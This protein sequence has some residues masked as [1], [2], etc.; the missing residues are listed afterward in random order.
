M[1]I[2]SEPSE[3]KEQYGSLQCHDPEISIEQNYELLLVA[4]KD[5][6]DETAYNNNNN[7]Q[8]RSYPKIFTDGA[9]S[10]SVI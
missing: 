1:R 4:L 7:E 10:K 2:N 5:A 6:D 9:I 8:R 3:T